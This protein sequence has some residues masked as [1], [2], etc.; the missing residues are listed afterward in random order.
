MISIRMRTDIH[1]RCDRHPEHRMVPVMMQLAAGAGQPWFPA[2]VCEQPE[3]P[4]Q[5]SMSEGYFNAFKQRI[6]PDSRRRVPCPHESLPMYLA[7][8]EPQAK[9]WTWRCAQFGCDG[10]LVEVGAA[11]HVSR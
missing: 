1:P 11:A 7:A 3:C 2:F 5:F 10:M 4:R 6:D 9:V 8:F